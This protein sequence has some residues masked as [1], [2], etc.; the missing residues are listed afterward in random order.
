MK[1][2]MRAVVERQLRQQQES[3]A[4]EVAFLNDLRAV[5][6]LR[7]PTS[8]AYLAWKATLAAVNFAALSKIKN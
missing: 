4:Y 1:Q 7:R 2:G 6:A 5:R 8:P 3:Q